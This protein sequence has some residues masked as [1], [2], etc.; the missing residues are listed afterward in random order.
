MPA[1][2]RS[3]E[4]AREQLLEGTNSADT[5]ILDS[6]FQNSE[7][8]ST[9]KTAVYDTSLWQHAVLISSLEIFSVSCNS[10]LPIEK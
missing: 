6:G 10:L 1:T 4:I 9:I 8:I 7:T 2:N 3:W 5:S